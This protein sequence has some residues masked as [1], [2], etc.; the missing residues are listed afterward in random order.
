MA[1]PKPPPMALPSTSEER[2]ETRAQAFSVT[3]LVARDCIRESLR[4]VA[5]P[6]S[7][8]SSSPPPRLPAGVPGRILILPTQGEKS[9]A[10]LPR[11]ARAGC[12]HGAHRTKLQES[13][14]RAAPMQPQEGLGASPPPR[15]LLPL[16]AITQERKIT[17][18]QRR[19]LAAVHLA[20]PAPPLVQ[21][22]P[23]AAG[24]MAR[25]LDT[26]ARWEVHGDPFLQLSL[27]KLLQLLPRRRDGLD[28][29][30][31]GGEDHTL[32]PPFM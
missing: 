16:Q 4:P 26:G 17:M 32:D 9:G 25:L 14:P 11:P 2:P 21:P 3:L 20:R 24:P 15:Q 28:P 27:I 30:V 18:T 8:A 19:P 1:P 6:G 29:S 10:A 23:P 31:D 7:P 22:P 5:P 13:R 12:P